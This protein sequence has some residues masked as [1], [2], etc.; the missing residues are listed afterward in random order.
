MT[1]EKGKKKEM[2]ADC[3]GAKQRDKRDLHLLS[4]TDPFE[5]MALQYRKRLLKL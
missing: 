2:F 1:G 4:L 3:P 5:V